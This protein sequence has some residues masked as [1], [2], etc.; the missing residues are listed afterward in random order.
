V[1]AYFLPHGWSFI[2]DKTFPKKT[3]CM[4]YRTSVWTILQSYGQHNFILLILKANIEY[5]EE[6]VNK[7]VSSF[8]CSLQTPKDAAILH[9]KFF[10]PCSFSPCYFSPRPRFPPAI[11]LPCI[12]LPPSI[13]LPVHF[14][15]RPFFSPSIFHPPPLFTPVH[16]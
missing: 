7:C 15:P 1:S 12:L 6:R 8:H 16:F 2:L 5:L 14:S 9:P 13:F 10:Q 4:L 11:L 3:N